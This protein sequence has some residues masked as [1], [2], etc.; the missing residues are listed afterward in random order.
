MSAK[1]CVWV[2]VL[3]NL[4]NSGSLEILDDD[5]E[6]SASKCPVHAKERSGGG[7]NC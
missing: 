5:E 7:W 2:D 3:M 4:G 6:R 1:L